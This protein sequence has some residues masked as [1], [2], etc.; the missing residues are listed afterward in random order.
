MSKSAASKAASLRQLPLPA[1][2]STSRRRRQRDHHRRTRTHSNNSQGENDGDGTEIVNDDDE[3]AGHLE[4]HDDDDDDSHDDAEEDIGGWDHSILNE[5]QD[6]LP[7]HSNNSASSS[8]PAGRGASVQGGRSCLSYHAMACGN[9]ILGRSS[10]WSNNKNDSYIDY[11]LSE[12][13]E[14]MEE[15]SSGPND[16]D[17]NN[18]C[19]RNSWWQT[20][21]DSHIHTLATNTTGS[22]IAVA[23]SNE[24]SLL[25]GFDGSVLAT[26]QICSSSS[27]TTSHGNSSSSSS[28]RRVE[29]LAMAAR[30]KKGTTCSCC[31]GCWVLLLWMLLLRMNEHDSS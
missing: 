18:N 23:T 2:S 3:D 29:T 16:N 28:S 5:S 8:L 4:F 6:D 20:S 21:I 15:N 22:V 12:H 1:T 11:S 13:E 7:S 31:T 19:S 26:R 30:S 24:V 14:M 10:N 9:V 27:T 25:K 17:I